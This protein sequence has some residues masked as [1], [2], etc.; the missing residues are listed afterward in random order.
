MIKF[1]MNLTRHSN[2]SRVEFKEYWE[3][4]HAPLFLKNAKKLGA[5]K[6][7]QSLTIDSPLNQGL[8]E[9]RGMLA[10]F[11]GVAEV[12]F[13]S[14]QALIEGMSSTQ[15]QQIAAALQADES[16]FIDHSKSAAY[17][18]EEQELL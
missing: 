3:Q 15:G 13:E 14:E 2:M 17:I 4:H 18:V 11:D 7:I 16:H 9:S 1:V 8:R 12:W 5:K 10:E 6:Y